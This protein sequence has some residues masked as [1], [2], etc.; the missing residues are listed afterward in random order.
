MLAVHCCCCC[1]LM[2]QSASDSMIVI[3]WCER[4]WWLQGR[5]RDILGCWSG[6]VVPLAMFWLK[7][8]ASERILPGRSNSS[9]V[10]ILWWVRQSTTILITD[11]FT[12]L[13][14]NITVILLC[15]MPR[16]AA[17][18]TQNE[19]KIHKSSTTGWKTSSGEIILLGYCQQRELR[20]IQ[21]R[22][23]F[24]LWNCFLFSFLL[25]TGP[26]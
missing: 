3:V 21:E 13:R 9:I 8:S 5:L 1:C 11:N 16:Y 15:R 22:K 10:T 26:G 4:G 23:E 18:S 20:N 12:S 19:R 6:S 24:K 2:V 25:N 7:G 14:D 17:N